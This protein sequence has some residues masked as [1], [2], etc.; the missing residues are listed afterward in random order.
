MS[1]TLVVAFALA[2][3]LVVGFATLFR[4]YRGSLAQQR[5][6]AEFI[7]RLQ[8]FA[9]AEGFENQQYTWL[10]QHSV[11]MQEALGSLGI[12]DYKPPGILAFISNYQVILN[13]LPELRR[14][15]AGEYHFGVEDTFREQAS[16]CM[17]TLVR[18]FGVLERR[19]AESV[20]QL[21]NPLAWFREGVQSI[22]LVPILLLASLGLLS[23][24]TVNRFR[25]S[26]VFRLL[27]GFAALVGL[28]SAVITIV[29]GWNQFAALIGGLFGRIPS[30]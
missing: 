19:S 8:R 27:A 16:L 13:L 14:L 15:R 3:I 6:T 9:S 4:Q 22:L 17:D 11:Q 26:P 7:S 29:L 18:Y 30:R 25:A 10:T 23:L 12:V 21:R 5:F 28:L 20:K 2:G 24:S 1:S